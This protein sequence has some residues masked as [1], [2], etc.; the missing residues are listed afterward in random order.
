MVILNTRGFGRRE[1]SLVQVFRFEKACLC[2]LL[3]RNGRLRGM[4]P[5]FSFGCSWPRVVVGK[6]V[7]VVRGHGYCSLSFCVLSRC[8]FQCIVFRSEEEEAE[9]RSPFHGHCVAFFPRS[10][11]GSHQR[12]LLSIVFLGSFFFCSK[13][14]SG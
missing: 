4:T 14:H 11:F 1:A 3:L 13:D 9:S 12:A 7:L 10:H 8:S 6:K 2:R 5:N